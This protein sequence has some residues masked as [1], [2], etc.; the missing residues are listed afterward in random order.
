MKGV[1]LQ[2][3]VLF[4]FWQTPLS[5]EEAVDPL[6][7]FICRI[8][9]TVEPRL[10]VFMSFPL[11]LLSRSGSVHS[12]ELSPHSN[13][14]SRD[15][16]PLHLPTHSPRSFLLVASDLFNITTV[17]FRFKYKKKERN[18]IYL[19]WHNL[20]QR[21]KAISELNCELHWSYKF[22]KKSVFVIAAFLYLIPKIG[23]IGGL[24]VRITLVLNWWG[25]GSFHC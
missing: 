20:R 23:G 17:I 12:L 6:S 18:V 1:Y 13:S 16:E 11:M 2:S 4:P 7:V 22:Q 15:E 14:I 8:A 24:D 5:L 9:P 21:K 3:N 19:F 10:I 25:D